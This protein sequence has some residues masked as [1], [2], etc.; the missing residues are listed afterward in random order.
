MPQTSRRE[1]VVDPEKAREKVF[2]AALRLL[3]ARPR[4]E[5]Q[6]REKL[7]AKSWLDASLIDVC[8]A[9]L[10]ELGYI[11]DRDYALQY[12]RA[13]VGARSIGRSRLARELAEKKV[14]RDLIEEALDTVFAEVTEAD[15]L[16]QAVA[17]HVRIHG[18]PED[19]KGAKKLMSHLLRRG[20]AYDRVAKTL[21]SIRFDV[22]DE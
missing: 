3:S 20:F 4:S 13:R 11:N 21:R 10:K 16:A 22:E 12:A 2:N 15:L 6:L 1:S 5:T 9:R 14:S 19:P 7:L 18:K 8:V 17:K